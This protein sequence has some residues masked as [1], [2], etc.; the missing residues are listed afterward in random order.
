MTKKY[1]NTS[2]HFGGF[3]NSIHEQNIDYMVEAYDYK[4][5]QVDYKKTF[6]SYIDEYCSKLSNY[7][8]DEYQRK[9]HNKNIKSL[10]ELMHDVSC[11]PY[12]TNYMTCRTLPLVAIGRFFFIRG[13]TLK[14]RIVSFFCLSKE[15]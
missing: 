13:E 7:I 10:K 5:D 9:L 14:R 12:S 8:N 4:F 3:Y 2:I 6:N 1:I 15:L 11:T